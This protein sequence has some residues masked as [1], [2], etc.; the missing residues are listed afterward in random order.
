MSISS[1]KFTLYFALFLTLLNYKFFAY[2]FSVSNL[3]N[4]I[5]VLVAIPFL[6]FA[7]MCVVFG[8]L[9]VP[10]LSKPLSIFLAIVGVIGAYFMNTY[11]TILDSE[12]IR[13]AV[14]TDTKEVRDLLSLSMLPWLILALL[15]VGFIIKVKIV[16]KPFFKEL[17]AKAIFVVSFLV[18]FSVVFAALSKDLVP[19]FRNHNDI[20]FYTTP[21]YP[22]YSTIKFSK[23]L[24]PKEPFKQIGL[25]ATKNDDTKRLFVFVLGETA[26][27]FD[28]SI[29]NYSLHDTNPYSKANDLLS[30][31]DFS[32]CGT[33]TAISVPCMFSNF[34]RSDFSPSKA[35]NTG[36][37]LDVLKTAKVNVSWLG[38]NSGWC[39][40]VCDR[41]SDSRDF[42]GTD[43]DEVM[44]EDVQKKISDANETSFIVVHL[45][46]SHGP[47]YFKRYPKEFDKFKPTC[48]T[49]TLKDCSH[50]Q[51]VNTYDNTILYTDYIVNKIV[52][53]LKN[54][55]KFETGL[56]YVSD[57]GESLGE[58]GIYLHG[59]PYALA[60]EFQTK[61]PAMLYLDDRTRLEKLKNLK[62][63]ELSQ[64]Y[65]FSSVLGFFGIKS[66]V[67]NPNLDIFAK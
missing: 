63:S 61:V 59:M 58:N 14:Q 23:S 13:N 39:K 4:D 15:V 33:S 16:Y 62:D 57:H 41:T 64:D 28:Y 51:I 1:N 56:F 34:T 54:N 11:G 37:L 22:L 8:L 42:G 49:A 30:F 2:T 26:R 7:L 67:Y 44:L 5:L 24:A 9:F 6:I 20:R 18:L 3:T 66:E 45:Q 50:E 29:N 55:T 27:S 25:D 38:N 46:G 17:G 32:S 36:N 53:M 40:G 43:F 48:D 10:F 35:S 52:D 31:S 60:P 21:F 12:M 19:F 65:I 47:T